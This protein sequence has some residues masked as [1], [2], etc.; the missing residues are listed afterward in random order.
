MGATV[1]AFWEMQKLSY[2]FKGEE[3]LDSLSED[4]WGWGRVKKW[5]KDTS[6]GSNSYQNKGIRI[7]LN[8]SEMRYLRNQ[9]VAFLT[10]IFVW[11]LELSIWVCWG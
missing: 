3:N 1:K 9:I 4:G 5:G 10:I 8:N 2:I 7:K 6:Q 11:L